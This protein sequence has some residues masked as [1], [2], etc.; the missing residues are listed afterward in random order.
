MDCMGTKQSISILNN[1]HVEFVRKA[2]V[3]N[4]TVAIF[5]NSAMDVGF[6]R[7]NVGRLRLGSRVAKR[8]LPLWTR[9][10]INKRDVA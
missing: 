5:V 6:A 10:Q 1:L 4:V 9:P 8:R 2:G 7:E 3:M